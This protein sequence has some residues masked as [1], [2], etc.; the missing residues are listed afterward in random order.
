M[1]ADPE[2]TARLHELHDDYVWKV[3][4]AVAEGR[5]DLI[6]RL[7]DEYVEEAA[8]ILVEGSPAGVGCGREGCQACA[9][10]RPMPRPMSRRDDRRRRWLG[11][12]SGGAAFGRPPGR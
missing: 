2:L 4:S 7:S 9:R 3:N 1:P 6:R 10:T 5:E 8:R 12:L 11:L